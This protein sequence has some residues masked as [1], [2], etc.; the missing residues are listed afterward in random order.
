MFEKKFDIALLSEPHLNSSE[1]DYED[2]LLTYLL[3]WPL[4]PVTGLGLS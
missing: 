4:Q 3:I 1:L 2:G